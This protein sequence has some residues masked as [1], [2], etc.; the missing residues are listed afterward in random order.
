MTAASIAQGRRFW[1]SAEYALLDSRY[2][3]E[4]TDVIAKDLRFDSNALMFHGKRMDWFYTQVRQ[5]RPSD[6][7]GSSHVHPQGAP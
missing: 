6:G 5:P 2:P 1:T 3:H 7:N 4:R